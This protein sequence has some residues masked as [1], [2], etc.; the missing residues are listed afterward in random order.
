MSW[1]KLGS[2]QVFIGGNE[3]LWDLLVETSAEKK[4]GKLEG[5]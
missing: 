5:R 1:G 4:K 2:P 3:D